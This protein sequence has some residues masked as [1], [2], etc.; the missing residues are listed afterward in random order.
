MSCRI[1]NDKVEIVINDGI[2]SKISVMRVAYQF[3][4]EYYIYFDYISEKPHYLKIV[5]EPKQDLNKDLKK[6]AGEFHNE[7]LNQNLRNAI[8]LKTKS[9]REL[10]LARALYSSYIDDSEAVSEMDSNEVYSINSIA[11]DWFDEK[12]NV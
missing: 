3:I 10:V 1:V 5:L 11:K 9:V 8:E 4:D 7:L 12:E 2:Y 6:T